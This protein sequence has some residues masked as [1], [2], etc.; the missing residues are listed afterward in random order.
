MKQ[1]NNVILDYE[2]TVTFTD[3]SMSR[4]EVG[5]KY[6]LMT[7]GNMYELFVS[8]IMRHKGEVLIQIVTTGL[9]RDIKHNEQWYT[10]VALEGMSSHPDVESFIKVEN[11]AL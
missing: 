11:Y 5:D 2:C 1:F 6:R 10:G 8:K 3:G 4:I 9:S 7:H